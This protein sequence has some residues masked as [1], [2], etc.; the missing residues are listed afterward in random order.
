[1]NCTLNIFSVVFID[2]FYYLFYI[3]LIGSHELHSSDSFGSINAKR[4]VSANFFIQL[5]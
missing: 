3:L 1:M 2:N 5:E 4:E